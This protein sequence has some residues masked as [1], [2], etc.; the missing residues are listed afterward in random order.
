MDEI[1]KDRAELEKLTKGLVNGF[2]Y[3]FGAYT[4]AIKK[5]LRQ[6][7]ILY[8]RTVDN[9][10]DFNLPKDLLEWNPTC[11]YEE[12]MK[13][14]DVFLNSKEPALFYIWGHSYEIDAHSKWGEVN[15]LLDKLG[16]NRDVWYA[17]NKEIAMYIDALH[18]L[19]ISVDGKTIYNPSVEDVWCIMNGR[20]VEISSDEYFETK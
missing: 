3:P 7:G 17:T 6:A 16:K 8:A 15:L 10:G 11:H 9:S 13:Y 20:V 4:E 5:L 19:E 18:R 12:A 14:A 2:S 1:L